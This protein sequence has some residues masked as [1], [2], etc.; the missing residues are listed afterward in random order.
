MHRDLLERKCWHK[1]PNISSRPIVESVALSQILNIEVP[2][3]SRLTVEHVLSLR[4]ER[5][6]SN[7]REF[8]ASISSTI[9]DDPEL[10]TDHGEMEKVIRYNYTR[11]LSTQLQKKHTTRFK[12]AIEL[13]L[14]VLSLIPGYGAI[15]TATSAV[16][17][18]KNYWNDKSTWY[19]FI[20]KLRETK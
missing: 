15:P 6:R 8:I 2:D 19:A 11:A 4:E 16:K 7:F 17:S 1:Q 14:G 5:S 10:L 13:G 18:L 3:F 12:L 20:L 9:K